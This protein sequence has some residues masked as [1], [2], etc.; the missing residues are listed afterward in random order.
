MATFQTPWWRI[1]LRGWICSSRHAA[2]RFAYPPIGGGCLL[3]PWRH[4][5]PT[6]PKS[7]FP[8][9]I[10]TLGLVTTFSTILSLSLS[11]SDIL[12]SFLRSYRSP[13]YLI[14]FVIFFSLFVYIYILSNRSFIV[15]YSYLYTCTITNSKIKSKVKEE[16]V[17]VQIFCAGTW[18]FIPV[19]RWHNYLLCKAIQLYRVSTL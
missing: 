17:N 7:F 14:P 19:Y 5:W 18:F 12:T 11:P 4:P 3:L 15:I 1:A 6:L 16:I 2:P 10:S 9:F 8:S 13:R